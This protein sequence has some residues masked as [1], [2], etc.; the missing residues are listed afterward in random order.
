MATLFSKILKGEIPSYPIAENEH[1]Y[2][3]LDINPLARGHTLVI[4]K[5]EV[6][7]LFDLED[8]WLRNMSVFAKHVARGID[9]V[10]TCERVGVAVLG[11]EI[12]HAHVHLIPIQHEGDIDFKKPKLQLTEEAFQQTASAIRSAVK[13]PH[14]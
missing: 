13:L 10:I 14:Q 8:A 6:D 5:L 4:P 11:M 3:F 1:Y 9:S 2:A 7:Y 12:P